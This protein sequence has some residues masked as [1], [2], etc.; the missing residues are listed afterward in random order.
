MAAFLSA[1]FVGYDKAPLAIRFDA[2][3]HL[4]DCGLS[5]L[6]AGR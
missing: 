1:T 6:L 5:N 2:D 3:R 4:S